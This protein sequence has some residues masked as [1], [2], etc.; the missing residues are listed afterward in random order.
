[1]IMQGAVGQDVPVDDVDDVGVV[2]A[3]DDLG[4]ALEPS[5]GLRIARDLGDR[6][7]SAKVRAI[8]RWRTA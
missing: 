6:V 4:L 2:E 3:G 7:L 8:L 5:H 1:M